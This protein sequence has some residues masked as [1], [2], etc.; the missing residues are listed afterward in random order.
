[1]GTH[2][3][4]DQLDEKT[5]KFIHY[6]NEPGNPK[7][8]SANYVWNLYEDR[9]GVI[10]VATGWPWDNKT[11]DGG[12]N[13]LET[14]GTFTSYKHD[15]NNPHSLIDNRVRA[16]FEDSRGVFWI[17][18]SGDGLHT[19]DRKT[20]RIER[21]TYDPARPDK[22]SRPPLKK[23]DDY[24]YNNDQVTFIQEDVVGSIWVGTWWS[25][26]NRYDTLTKKITHYENSNGFP[27]KS[28]ENIYQS[29]DGVLWIT[30]QEA[31]LYRV[32]P[33]FRKLNRTSTPGIPLSFIDDKEGNLWV[34]TL[35]GGLLQ[36]N[37]EGKLLQQFNH[38]P[39]DDRSLFDSLNVILS[40][41][42]RN[43]D[44]I[45]LG[46][47]D[48]P[49]IFNKAT[50]EFSRLPVALKYNPQSSKNIPDIMQ[51]SHGLIWFALYG[52]GLLRYNPR[53]KTS[54]Q[55]LHNEKD[56]TSLTSDRVVSAFEDGSGVIWVGDYAAGI[57]RLEGDRETFRH[58]L[59]GIPCY[60]L[61]ESSSGSL[62]LTTNAGLYAYN[63]NE[64]KFS[65]L[66]DPA[67]ELSK[68]QTNHVEEDSEK[69]LWIQNTSSLVKLNPDTQ[70]NLYVFLEV[71]YYPE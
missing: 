70:G 66:F 18:T 32:D 40:M 19:M 59:K 49:G 25:G 4:L 35:H 20:G 47:S 51:D 3:G 23:N 10:W 43:G 58:Y 60:T 29:R 5:G 52:N 2:K 15:P 68:S 8:L 50:R 41:S 69:Q 24:A 21:H 7:S 48:G 34:G 64:D 71:W 28:G 12:L 54:K 17:G 56:T 39:S 63:R 53:D 1:M 65:N 57:N 36:Y 26:I 13:R 62:Y 33:F 22:L 61:N 11:E 37:Q 31:N 44:T 55:F 45:W 30:T 6:R 27:D 38:N 14:D 67:S 9:Q 16:M 46:T 42:H